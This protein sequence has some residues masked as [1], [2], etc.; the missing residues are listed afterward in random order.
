MDDDDEEQIVVISDHLN[1]DLGSGSVCTVQELSDEEAD[2]A[3]EEKNKDEKKVAEPLKKPAPLKKM[4][5]QPVTKVAGKGGKQS[6]APISPKDKAAALKKKPT[7]TSVGSNKG[8]QKKDGAK[9]D[10]VSMASSNHVGTDKQLASLDAK[11]DKAT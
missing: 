9:S 1:S 4:N 6:S 2:Q 10:N 5:T 7:N 11:Y 3:P 8:P